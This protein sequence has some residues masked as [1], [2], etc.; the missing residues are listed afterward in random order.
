[1]V[2]KSKCFDMFQHTKVDGV[3]MYE[4]QTLKQTLDYKIARNFR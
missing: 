4:A 3:A 2:N 1:M